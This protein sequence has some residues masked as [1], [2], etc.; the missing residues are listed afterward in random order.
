MI[1][2]KLAALGAFAQQLQARPAGYNEVR[3][4]IQELLVAW[5]TAFG[6]QLGV[7]ANERAAKIDLTAEILR[8]WFG[9]A[10]LQQPMQIADLQRASVVDLLRLLDYPNDFVPV[11]T[12]HEPEAKGQ[13]ARERV[14]VVD[15]GALNARLAR[16]YLAFCDPGEIIGPCRTFSSAMRTRTS[17]R[18]AGCTRRSPQRAIR[19]GSIRRA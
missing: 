1:G 11:L 14:D 8:R 15:K 9:D 12:R 3:A 6:D 19:F 16:S 18:L 4:E 7:H 13:P 2:P 10:M 5:R 17:K